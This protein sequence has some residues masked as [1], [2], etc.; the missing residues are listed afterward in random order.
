[1]VSLDSEIEKTILLNKE[2]Y[3]NYNNYVN[4]KIFLLNEQINISRSIGL[5]LPFEENLNKVSTSI[6]I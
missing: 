3:K 4:T 5:K 6:K 1:M 2:I